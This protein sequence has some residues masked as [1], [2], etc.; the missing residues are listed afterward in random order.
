MGRIDM[1]T[2]ADASSSADLG[3]FAAAIGRVGNHVEMLRDRIRLL[4]AVIE[5]FPGG[6]S[7]FDDRLQ[8]VL[9]NEQQKSLL[10]YPDDLF[11]GGFPTLESLFR[12]NASRGEYGP[13]DV[14]EQV[15]RRMS[16]VRERKAH[17]YE[18]TRPNGTVLEVRGTPIEGGGF[19][20]TYL[21]VTEQRR[22]QALIAY[23]AHHDTL[24]NLPNRVL[25]T[26]RLQTAIALAKRSGLIAVHYLDIDNFKPVNDTLG[27]QA[28]DMLLRAIA[29]RLGGA[30]RENDTVARLGGDEFAIVQTGIS[31]SL[32]AA[33]LARR[34]LEQLS[35]PFEVAGHAVQVGVSIGIALSPRDGIT[36]DE[37]LIKADAALYRSKTNGRGRFSFHN[38]PD[39]QTA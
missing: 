7:L 4:E 10:D 36:I 27:H 16:L 15:A 26:D 28:G 19:V 1:A 24:T 8:M 35:S 34:V 5:N 32:H 18:R 37:I 2:V 11:A 6:I 29:R 9:C 33:V 12:F 14:E 31:E 23:M 25:F 22:N 39:R 30:V 3:A 21:D 17:V 38:A 20:T 13:G